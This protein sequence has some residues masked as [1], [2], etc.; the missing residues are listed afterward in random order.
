MIVRLSL[1]LI[2]AATPLAAQG[3]YDCLIDPSLVIELGS[4]EV[5]VIEQVLVDRG[6]RVAAGQVIA[7]LESGAEQAALTYARARAEDRSLVEIAEARVSLMRDQAERARKLGE[8]ALLAEAAVA[9]VVGE[10]EQ[11]VLQLRQAEV[12]QALARLEQ[13]RVEAT[14]GRRVIRSPVDG[15]VISRMVGPGEYVFAEAPVAQIAQVD[16]LHVEVFLPIDLF[17]G[18]AVG[19]VA[20]VFPAAPIGG[21]R[22]A[23]IIVID[24]VFDAA[25]D[26]FGVRLVM[27]NADGKLAA[28][29]DCTI[30]FD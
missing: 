23:R 14:L 28:G 2:C 30:S 22:Q 10:Y 20:Q 25:S 5:G 12:E 17:P 6:D 29:L 1:A 13:S 18:L 26:T 7:T 15:L 24:Q 4:A 9:E 3:Q 16:P 19:D 8:R 21:Q 27:D 11:A